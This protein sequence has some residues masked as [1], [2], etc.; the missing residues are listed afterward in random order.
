MYKKPVITVLTSSASEDTVK[1]IAAGIE[2]EGLLYEVLEGRGGSASALAFEAAGRSAL[3]TGIGVLGNDICV[4]IRNLPEA[5]P[6]FTIPGDFKQTPRDIG[7]N[8]ARYVKKIPFN[9]IEQ[10]IP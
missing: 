4:H 10:V 6:L 1:D 3:D 9:N 8:A 2:E 5:K 7:A